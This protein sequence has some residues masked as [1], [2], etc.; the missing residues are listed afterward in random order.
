MEIKCIVVTPEKVVLEKSAE[1]VSLPLYDGD[2][3]IAF[4]HTPVIGRL[5]AGELRIRDGETTDSY[6]VSGGFVE[7]LN[8]SVTLMTSRA[9]P[10]SQITKETAEQAFAEASAK[11]ASTVEEVE[12]RNAALQSARAMLR[13]VNK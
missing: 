9:I 5:G 3:G 13:I 8:N 11:P 1:F 6:F 10:V 7:V 2:Y 12:L 4:N